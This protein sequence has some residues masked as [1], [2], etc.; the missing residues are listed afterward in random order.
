MS[1]HTMK[2]NSLPTFEN[3]EKLIKYG[4]GQASCWQGHPYRTFERGARQTGIPWPSSLKAGRG[5]EILTPKN[6]SRNPSNG[7][8]ITQKRGQAP[9]KNIPDFHRG[10]NEIFA[11]LKCF[12]EG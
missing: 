10:V 4:G 11:L 2:R 9:Q 12:S 6:S 1:C 5:T 8:T 3:P 7:Q